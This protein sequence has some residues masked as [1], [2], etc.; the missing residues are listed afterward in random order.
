MSEE[1]IRPRV[2]VTGFASLLHVPD[3][4]SERLVKALQTEP[5]PDWADW[6]YVQL[7]TIYA[8]VPPRLTAILAKAPDALILTGYS[9]VANGLKLETGATDRRSPKFA[10]ATGFVPQ[11]PAT[12]PRRID[13][14]AVDFAALRQRLGGAGVP[15]HLSGDAGEY[16]CNHSYYEALS[17]IRAAGAPTRT[18]FVHIP[19][20]EG[21][22][23]A[24][25]SASALPLDMIAKGVR[26]VAEELARP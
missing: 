10:D 4:P 15:H 5:Q 20:I 13:N 1:R 7:D 8:E 16:V 14:E 2:V 11:D 9:G 19:A 24:G 17:H 26:L 12:E 18:I 22:D 21:S 23:L 3:N 25:T 6:D